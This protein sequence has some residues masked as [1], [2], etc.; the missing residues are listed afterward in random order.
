MVC[1]FS[2]RRFATCSVSS[3][4]ITIPYLSRREGPDAVLPEDD[5]PVESKRLTI[6]RKDNED[7]FAGGVEGMDP[8]ISTG[9]TTRRHK[10]SP[11]TGSRVTTITESAEDPEE[12]LQ[13]AAPLREIMKDSPEPLLMP[14]SAENVGEE[15]ETPVEAA[16]SVAAEKATE[17][18]ESTSAV[19]EEAPEE[20]QQLADPQADREAAKPEEAEPQDGDHVNTEEPTESTAEEVTKAPT[21][22]TEDTTEEATEDT[23]ESAEPVENAPESEDATTDQDSK[24]SEEPKPEEKTES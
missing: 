17:S 23:T 11:S 14:Q 12:A 6:L 15:Q 2:L 10:H 16:D 24:E 1:I 7:P 13:S 5:E 3:R 8:S 9:A 22:P 4:K 18:T 21:G 19:H 20:V